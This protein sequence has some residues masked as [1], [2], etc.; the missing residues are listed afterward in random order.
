LWNDKPIVH[1]ITGE[2]ILVLKEIDKAS[3][4]NDLILLKSKGIDS[5]AVALMHSYT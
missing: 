4:K 2:E 5:I 3:L 1:G